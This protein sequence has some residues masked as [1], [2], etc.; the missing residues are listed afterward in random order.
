MAKT[1]GR[2]ERCGQKFKRARISGRKSG[3]Q[4][5]NREKFSTRI[6]CDDCG[7]ETLL[8]DT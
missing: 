7:A 6:Q 5:L 1:L 4:V 8:T 2:C 3:Y